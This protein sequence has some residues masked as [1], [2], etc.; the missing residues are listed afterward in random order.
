MPYRSEGDRLLREIGGFPVLLR[1]IFP[2]LKLIYQVSASKRQ[3]IAIIGRF[4]QARIPFRKS[5]S[6]IGVS[7]SSNDHFTA[8]IAVTAGRVRFGGKRGEQPLVSPKQQQFPGD[9][10]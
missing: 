3:I 6:D 5:K 10:R 2:Q 1:V 9:G 7:I 4:F 8:E